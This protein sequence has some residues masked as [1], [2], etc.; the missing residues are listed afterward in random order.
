MNKPAKGATFATLFSEAQALQY[1]ITMAL[2]GKIRNNMWAVFVI[3]A[4]ATLSFILMDAMGPGG[5]GPTVNTAVGEIAGQKIS[6]TEFESAYRTL[7]NNSNDPNASRA[8]LWNYFVE[9]KVVKKEAEQLGLS[10][11]QD[12]YVDLQFGSK[13][14]PIVYQNFMNPATG[15]LD[16]AQL[17]QI[18][19]QIESGAE[20]APQFEQFWKEQ[21]KQIIKAQLQT[22]LSSI[23]QKAVYTPNWMAETLYSEENGSADIAV[24]K[25]PFDNIPAGDISVSDADIMNFVKENREDFERTEEKRVIEYVKMDVYPT[26]LDSIN[27]RKEVDGLISEFAT[28]EN[29]SVFAINNNGFY[30]DFY[31]K[32]ETVD[33]SYQN[34]LPNYEVGK[35]YGPYLLRNVYQAVK[36]LDKRVVPD[37]VRASHILRRATPGSA[38]QMEE[39]ER[40]IDSLLIVAQRGRTPFDTLAANFSEDL[41]NSQ[42]GGDL[43][44]FAQGAMVGPFNKTAFIDGKEG[45][46]YKVK[47][48]FGVHLV[49]IVDQKYETREPKYQLAFINTP[50]VPSKETQ[51]AMYE[52]MVD[53][54]SSHPYLDD[55]KAAVDKIG[56]LSVQTSN[57]VGI[58]DYQINGLQS[59]SV[60]RDV[61]KWAFAE[62]TS[63]N[64]V[65]AVVYQF[66]DPVLYYNNAY[67]VAGLG[68]ILKPGMPSV[69]EVRNQV[70]FAVLNKLKGEK[71]LSAITSTDLNAVASQYNSAV[72]TL[73]GVNMLNNFVAGL[74]NEPKVLGA[75]F[76]QEAGST[77]A[78]I[79]G[80]S[81]V[82]VVKTL[83]KQP[84]GEATNIAYIKKTTADK[85]KSQ[86]VSGLMEALKQN[87]EIKDNRSAFY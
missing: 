60:T 76:G 63:T 49:H 64:D 38:A 5:G 54:V 46:Y 80:N 86:A 67:V 77:S 4:L 16:V 48:Q 62:G 11:G 53:L 9:E 74:G 34:D 47:T 6:N 30:S 23:A 78:P 84:A 56:N 3:I 45:G 52:N 18:K 7:F 71:A 12:E 85:T 27:I 20:M 28:T 33:E 21:G 55:L 41:A 13:L 32:A 26:A 2:I 83:N 70:E 22:K 82:F 44:Y 59:G 37:S 73:R 24:V 50:I 43:G 69:S 40:L 81:G 8:A 17:Q 36:L 75:A 1:N 51:N 66:Q 58:N 25:V 10:V 35:V 15:Q 31:V 65:S 87:V 19:Q 68:S 42:D 39:A 14:S 79:L 72:D 57:E 29:D 61:I